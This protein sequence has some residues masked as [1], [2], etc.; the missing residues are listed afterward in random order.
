[1]RSIGKLQPT[2]NAFG[3]SDSAHVIALTTA[4]TAQDYPA[5]TRM[6]RVDVSTVCFFNMSSTQAHVPAATITATTGSSGL[7][8]VLNTGQQYLFQV[9]GNTTGYSI[10]TDSTSAIV[11]LQFYGAS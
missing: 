3:Q 6:V 4:T 8:Q 9:S 2:A 5:D 1:M 7:T 11:S 10:V